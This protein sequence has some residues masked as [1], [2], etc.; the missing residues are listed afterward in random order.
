MEFQGPNSFNECFKKILWCVGIWLNHKY[1]WE[2]SQSKVAPCSLISCCIFQ[3][4]L[5]DSQHE[6]RYA[7]HGLFSW[8]PREWTVM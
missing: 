5:F 6:S 3:E 4:I 2:T 1:V 8:Y 7:N